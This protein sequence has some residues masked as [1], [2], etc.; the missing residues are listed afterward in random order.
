M[1]L[2]VS[3]FPAVEYRRPRMMVSLSSRLPVS[4]CL[5]S[6]RFPLNSPR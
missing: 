4:T 6:P 3:A 1:T 5:M 2:R